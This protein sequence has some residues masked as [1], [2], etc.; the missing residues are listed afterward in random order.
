MA[1]L[2]SELQKKYKR[3]QDYLEPLGR[4]AV[5]YSG[6][7]DSTFLLYAAAE[8]LGRDNALGIIANSETLSEEELRQATEVAQQLG[9]R[10]HVISYSELEIENYAE[11]PVNRCYFC[12]DALFTRVGGAAKEQGFPQ[13]ADGSIHDDLTSDYRPGM[14]AATE[15]GVLSPLLEV[16]LRKVDIR[17]LARAFDVPNWGKP[18]GACLSSRFP[19]G[20]KITRERLEHIP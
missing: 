3:L 11:N 5:A 6:G 13:I 14:R 2:N 8:T 7:I 1:K 12:R 4:L 19:Y 18:S 9:F 20:T 16:Q 15:Q 10:L 17:A